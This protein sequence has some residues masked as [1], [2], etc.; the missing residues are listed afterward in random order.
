MKNNKEGVAQRIRALRKKKDCLQRQVAKAI[1]VSVTNYGNW[2]RG[3]YTPG[4]VNIVALAR[5]FDVSPAYI[6]YG[7]N[8]K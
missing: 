3:E 2:E 1:E 8:K 4:S 5:Y 6:L 7:N